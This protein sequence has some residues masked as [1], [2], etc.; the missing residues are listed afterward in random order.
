MF[1]SSGPANGY[2]TPRIYDPSELTSNLI[3]GSM[4]NDNFKNPFTNNIALY[5]NTG[6]NLATTTYTVP[7]RGADG[8]ILDS[9][10]QDFIILI[11]YTGDQAPVSS[12]TV[13]Y[14]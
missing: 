4:A 8:M 2:S 7:L 13:S 10:L 14:T 12:I 3:S 5:G 11:R 1:K 6:G 9:T